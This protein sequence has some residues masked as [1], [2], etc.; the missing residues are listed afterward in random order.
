M[1]EEQA[2]LDF[3]AQTENL[4]LALSV[5]DQ[6][7]SLRQ[8]LNRAFWL[9]LCAHI[10]KKNPDWRVASTED[11]N[12]TD[13]LVGLHLQPAQEQT[14][15]LRPMLEQQY[16]GDTLRIYY[17]LMW[18]TLP[19][20][21]QT[22]L[23]AIN[24]LRDALQQEGFKNNE[25]FLAWQWTPY[26]PRRRD[27]LLRYNLAAQA[28]LDEAAELLD[29]LLVKHGNALRTANN[30]LRQAPR[31]ATVSLNQLRANL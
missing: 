17:G 28:L 11:R 15:Y 16:L 25:N 24:T 9:A 2:V 29:T 30:A 26:H 21:E 23:A 22:R 31:S 18:S 1:N 13:C 14:L 6:V 8:Q 27:F 4:P 12:A 20:P 5:A 7:D 3:F 10:A 19:T